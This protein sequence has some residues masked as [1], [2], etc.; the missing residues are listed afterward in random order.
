MDKQNCWELKKGGREPMGVNHDLGVC[1]AAM[2]TRLDSIHGG[3][4]G[5][6]ACWVVAG[7]LCDKQ[8]QGSFAKK[9]VNCEKCDFYGLVL[10]EEGPGYKP[11]FLLLGKLRDESGSLNS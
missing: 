4:N 9:Y 2:E 10:D 11:A 8:V 5:G 7:T 6:R 3:K 1:P